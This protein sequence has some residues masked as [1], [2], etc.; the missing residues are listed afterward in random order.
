MPITL[1]GT[2]GIILSGAAGLSQTGDGELTLGNTLDV[3]S[4]G[5]GT[6]TLIGIVKGDG[7]NALTAGKVDLATEISGT[8]NVASGGTG[9]NSLTGVVKA[10]GTNAFT[11]GVV[12]LTTE[13]GGV[14]NVASGGT[15]LT[16]V[17]T[18]GNVLTSDGT[19]WVSQA[20]PPPSAGSIQAVASGTLADGTKVILN[21]NGTVSAISTTLVSPPTV[22][23]LSTF[24]TVGNSVCIGFD[25]DKGKILVLYTDASSYLMATIGTISGESGWS[26]DRP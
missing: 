15:G 4:G 10:S 5:T 14:L 3:A 18:S 25:S 21:A 13:V 6:N 23:T 16:S 17:G 24:S 1:D 11:A 7:S 26:P 19:S 22:D 2:T 12:N 8:L 9:A 20:L